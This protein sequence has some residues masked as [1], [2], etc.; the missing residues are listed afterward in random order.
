[1]EDLARF[2]EDRGRRGWWLEAILE[3][4]V[5]TGVYDGDRPV[6]YASNLP[7]A[8]ESLLAQYRTTVARLNART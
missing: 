2:L 7:L 4:L 1:M 6:L 3:G 8:V 5:R